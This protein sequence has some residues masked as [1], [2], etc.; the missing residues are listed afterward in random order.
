[1]VP[2]AS[3]EKVKQASKEITRWTETLLWNQGQL[4][5]TLG[6]V[7]RA[8]FHESSLVREVAEE[9]AEVVLLTPEQAVSEAR[10]ELEDL[11]ESIAEHNKWAK[12]VTSVIRAY[13][14]DGMSIRSISQTEPV[15]EREV[16]EILEQ[17]GV[18]IR[19]RRRGDTPATPT[20]DSLV[21]SP[22]DGDASSENRHA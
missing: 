9:G 4:R 7:E 10:E 22:A 5:T 20:V 14:E 6:E 16:R 18:A 15:S 3:T 12:V 11:H 2:A 21:T 8:G 17:H 19:G 13:I 1:M